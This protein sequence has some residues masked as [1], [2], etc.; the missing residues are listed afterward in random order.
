[1]KYTT[2]PMYDIEG[3]EKNIPIDTVKLYGNFGRDIFL[4]IFARF[5]PII[6]LI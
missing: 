6:G 4:L 5:T 2:N 3:I 1:M